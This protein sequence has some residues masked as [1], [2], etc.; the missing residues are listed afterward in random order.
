MRIL[1]LLAT[2][3]LLFAACR[4]AEKDI[5]KHY[6]FSKS[7]NTVPLYLLFPPPPATDILPTKE[8]SFGDWLASLPVDS[9]HTVLHYYTGDEAL[10]QN[11]HAAII[12]IPVKNN[13][14]DSRKIIMRLYA[15]Y[16]YQQGRYNELQFSNNEGNIINPKIWFSE[17]YP[18]QPFQ[19][20]YRDFRKYLNETLAA[21]SWKSWMQKLEKI[22]RL[23][24]QAGDIV[25]QKS[26]GGSH[27]M[28]IAAAA[29]GRNGQRY[30]LYI[31]G[32]TPPAEVHVVANNEQKV[33]SP[34]YPM[35]E[36]Q[37]VRT[38]YWVFNDKNYYRL[39][40]DSSK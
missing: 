2:I 26:G 16:L 30:H 5:E 39:V 6:Y 38:P 13:I 33:L 20:P 31:E 12:D 21:A 24:A 23:E 9:A 32:A 15:E 36:G 25:Y 35:I 17:K 18:G 3:V 19:F 40:S 27:A 1:P 28:L 4:Q 22:S 10:Q 14:Q 11:G 37:P 34:W 7:E 29:N 8:G